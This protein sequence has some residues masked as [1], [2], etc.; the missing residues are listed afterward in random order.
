[1]DDRYAI[2]LAKT[3]L[4][5]GYRRGDI[6]Q[7]LAIFADLFT[8]MS[9]GVASFYGADAKTAL[10]GR[11][12]KLFLAYEVEWTPVIIDIAI[13]GDVAMEHGWHQMTLHP[14]ASGP[15]ATKRTRYVQMW[16]RDPEGGWRIVL[17]IDNDDHTPALLLD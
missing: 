4:R 10:R 16:R 17:F 15:P 2:N 5:E 8:D 3:E 12:K 9:D 13:T 11:L 6:E 7:I 14:K 1:M